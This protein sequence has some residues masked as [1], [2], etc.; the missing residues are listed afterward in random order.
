MTATQTWTTLWHPYV[1]VIFS[2]KGLYLVVHLEV[3]CMMGKW[4]KATMSPAVVPVGI[5]PGTEACQRSVRLTDSQIILCFVSFVLH[6]CF[7]IA[8]YHI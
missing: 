5:G 8:R 3:R 6:L 1:V 7:A 2:L 4:E